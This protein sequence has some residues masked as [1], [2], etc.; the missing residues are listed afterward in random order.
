MNADTHEYFKIELE[1][2]RKLS[3]L[4]FTHFMGV[5]YFWIGVVTFPATAGLLTTDIE[6]PQKALP[7][8]LC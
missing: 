1:H 7:T 3:E 6:P 8:S 2:F 5:F 4:Q